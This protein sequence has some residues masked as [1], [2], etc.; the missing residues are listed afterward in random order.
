LDHSKLLNNDCAN[1]PTTLQVTT[2][3]NDRFSFISVRLKHRKDFCFLKGK[4]TLNKTAKS[5]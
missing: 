2:K 4:P 3:R 5:T 1:K